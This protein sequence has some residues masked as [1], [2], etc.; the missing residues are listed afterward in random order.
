MSWDELPK[1]E[2]P[3]HAFREVERAVLCKNLYDPIGYL[4]KHLIAIANGCSHHY[5]PTVLDNLLEIVN[6]GSFI[7]VG[8]L[9]YTVKNPLIRWQ[10]SEPD[11]KDKRKHKGKWVTG[12]QTRS[13]KDEKTGCP[14]FPSL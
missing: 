13:G 1:I 2:H 3:S 10:S 4:E 5:H 14:V 11:S 6:H 8:S 12:R 9:G 7:L